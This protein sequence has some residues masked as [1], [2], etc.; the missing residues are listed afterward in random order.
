VLERPEAKVDGR[1]DSAM[2]GESDGVPA[3]SAWRIEQPRSR[4]K[5]EHSGEKG[6][7]LSISLGVRPVPL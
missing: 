6:D 7:L 2:S 3:M 4:L 1:Y 5:I